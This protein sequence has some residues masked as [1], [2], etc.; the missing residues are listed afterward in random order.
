MR[1]SES[2]FQSYKS[3]RTLSLANLICS[4]SVSGPKALKKLP[5]FCHSQFMIV[6]MYGTFS[7]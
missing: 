3:K 5:S 1:A 2:P 4:S 6:K 7:K